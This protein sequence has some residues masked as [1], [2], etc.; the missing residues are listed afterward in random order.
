VSGYDWLLRLHVTGAFFLL[1]GSVVAAL[2]NLL[3][4]RVRLDA[5]TPAVGPRALG[6]LGA[7]YLVLLAVAWLAVS[8]K[9]G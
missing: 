8:G 5:E 6:G 4:A 9:W 7:L 2:L 1:G 3:A